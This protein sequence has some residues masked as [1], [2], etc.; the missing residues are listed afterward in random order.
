MSM[1]FKNVNNE[2]E[3]EMRMDEE[4]LVL[5]QDEE[6]LQEQKNLGMVCSYVNT[7]Y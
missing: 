7:R 2:E 1:I 6:W 3:E 5:K 4:D